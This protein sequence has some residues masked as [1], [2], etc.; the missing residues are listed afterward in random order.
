MFHTTFLN[1]KEVTQFLNC[2]TIKKAPYIENNGS[3]HNQNWIFGRHMKGKYLADTRCRLNS[4]QRHSI[5]LDDHVSMAAG[6]APFSLR[7]PGQ[8]LKSPLWGRM[9]SKP[10]YWRAGCRWLTFRKA[11]ASRTWC[12]PCSRI[13]ISSYF[14]QYCSFLSKYKLHTKTRIRISAVN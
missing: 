7:K 3:R 10:F 11:T 13:I 4:M 5:S 8:P 2:Q 1:N 6:T 14:L 9:W 12:S